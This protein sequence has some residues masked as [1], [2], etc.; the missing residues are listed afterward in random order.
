[1]IKD[2]RQLIINPFIIA[3]VFWLTDGLLSYSE[4]YFKSIETLV[5]IKAI[6]LPVITVAVLFIIAK[7]RNETRRDIIV[8][9]FAG[10]FWIW[11]LSSYYLL[12]LMA[13]SKQGITSYGSFGWLLLAF[14][15]IA[16][17]VSTFSGGVIGLCLTTIS[18]PIASIII[19][20]NK[21]GFNNW[22]DS[23]RE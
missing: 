4:H 1:M 16:I 12:A 21:K 13:L 19:K 20:R 7:K 22:L 2:L 8:S 15:F 10:V 14:P 11:F 5:I 17:E 9:S 18:L 23:D 3:S 6:C